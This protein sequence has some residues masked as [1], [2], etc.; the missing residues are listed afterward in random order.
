MQQQEHFSMLKY[1]IVQA[2]AKNLG[3]NQR[4]H[5]WYIHIMNN[6]ATIFH[7]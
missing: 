1:I 2:Y 6:K 5:H 4:V 7:T 3:E